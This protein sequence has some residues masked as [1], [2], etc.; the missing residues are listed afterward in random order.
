MKTRQNLIISIDDREHGDQEVLNIRT[1]SRE[2]IVIQLNGQI[3]CMAVHPEDL[4]EALDQIKVFL[5]ERKEQPKSLQPVP[6]S[7]I[8]AD[9]Q[10]PEAALIE[11]FAVIPDGVKKEE[12][13]LVKAPL[14]E[15]K[16]L[17]LSN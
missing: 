8:G 10:N 13:V 16:G 14:E 11:K 9:I 17:D 6:S 1:T 3:N 12:Q 7:I 15:V 4:Q 5:S 2:S